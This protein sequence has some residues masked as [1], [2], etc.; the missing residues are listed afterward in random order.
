MDKHTKPAPCGIVCRTCRHL[1]EGCAG[2]FDGGGDEKC[3]IRAC[4]AGKGIAGCWECDEF[5][6]EHIQAK[7]PAWRGLTIGLVE[8]IKEHGEE[9]YA[10]LALQNIGEFAEYGDLRFKSPEEIKQVVVGE[11]A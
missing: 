3:H 2:C 10:E 8:S 6:C 7:D 4:T 5:P 11:G 1:N 9:R